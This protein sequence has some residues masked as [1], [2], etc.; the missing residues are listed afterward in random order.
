MPKRFFA[1]PFA[2]SPK[3]LVEFSIC[4]NQKLQTEA[5]RQSLADS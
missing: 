5:I 2:V 4:A 3:L 1:N